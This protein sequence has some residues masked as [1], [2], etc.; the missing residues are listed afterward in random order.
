MAAMAEH[1]GL[2]LV[3]V[4]RQALVQAAEGGGFRPVGRQPETGPQTRAKTQASIDL[5][6]SVS[7]F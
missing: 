6:N 4:K 3:T 5:A 2:D 1:D 7:F